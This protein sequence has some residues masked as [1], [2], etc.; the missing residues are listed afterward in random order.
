MTDPTC[1]ICWELQQH[2]VQVVN[3]NRTWNKK[4]NK[5]LICQVVYI[6]FSTYAGELHAISLREKKEYKNEA[7]RDPPKPSYIQNPPHWLLNMTKGDQTA[8][9]KLRFCGNRP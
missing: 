7:K 8:N 2:V 1:H 5:E 4:N 6:I 3:R 9:Q